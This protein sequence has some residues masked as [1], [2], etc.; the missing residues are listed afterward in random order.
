M[1]RNKK[2]WAGILVLAL[3][4]AGGG[5]GYSKWNNDSGSSKTETII[6]KKVLRQTLKDT[7]TV[8]GTLAREELRNVTAV[9]QGRV[10]A[11]Y[12]K[13]GSTGQVGERLFALD[14]RDAIA[15]P[16]S[17]QFFR[18]LGVGDIGD[19]VLQLKQILAA[20]GDNPG[21]MSNLFTDQTQFALGQ[22]QAQHR[23]PDATPVAPQSVTVSLAQGAGYTLGNQ[24]A[25]GLIIGAGDAQTAAATSGAAR[26]AELTAFRSADATPAAAPVLTIHSAAAEVPQGTPAT[27][28]IS[29]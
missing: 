17:V 9:S 2:M 18:P 12:A 14:G 16:G 29:A 22:W 5:F 4:A 13:D 24:T 19:D 15:E 3:V 20:A 10:S 21:P 11:V 28:V 8:N 26:H 7:V 6:L 23:Y 25:A 1:L 27:F